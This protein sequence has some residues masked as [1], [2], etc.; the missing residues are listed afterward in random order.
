MRTTSLLFVLTAIAGCYVDLRP[1]LSAF[2]EDRGA[3]NLTSESSAFGQAYAADDLV[4]DAHAKVLK[5][6]FFDHDWTIE[7]SPEGAI[8]RRIV[9]VYV[10]FQKEDGQCALDQMNFAQESTGPNAWAAVR[11]HGPGNPMKGARGIS[12]NALG[13]ASASAQ[14][15]R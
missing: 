6:G 10:G 7:R 11:L 8:L 13:A 12:C 15:S 3:P 1:A 2:P 9:S 5:I 4:R 14:A